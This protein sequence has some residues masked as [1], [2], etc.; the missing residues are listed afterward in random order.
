MLKTR[1]SFVQM[2]GCVAGVVAGMAAVPEVAVASLNGIDV[3]SYQG[4]VNWQA[5]KNAGTSF[6]FA[7]A[8]EGTYYTDAYLRRNISEMKR[9]GIIPGAY[10][11]ARPGSNA[12]TQARIFCSA[13]K[14]ANG[15]NFHGL[16]QLALDLE[17]TDGQSPTA[18]RNWTQAFIHEVQVQTGRPGIIYTGF[19]FWRDQAGN[20]PNLN[21]PL[22]LA[23]YVSNPTPY[24]PAAWKSVGWAFWQYTSSGSVGGT[25]PVDR[26]YFRNAYPYNNI[27]ALRIP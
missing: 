22:W 8:T 9:V 5:V 23:A 2:L 18:I 6:A 13:V 17:R 1:R 14:S 3:S 24:I 20:G 21:C 10:H 15:N 16:L 11:F 27:G 4:Y 12:V 7:K 26:D 19:Y 25:H